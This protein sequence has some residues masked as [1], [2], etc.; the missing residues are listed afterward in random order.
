MLSALL[1]LQGCGFWL[2]W[3]AGQRGVAVSAIPILL[4][5]CASLVRD[6]ARG[7][8]VQW[9]AGSWTLERVGERQGVVI[10]PATT[11]LPWV[12]YLTWRNQGTGGRGQL[13][14]FSDSMDRDKLRRLRARLAL[15]R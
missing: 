5:V 1:A 4:L 6:P 8:I 3:Q 11:C 14:L 13:W 7:T 2:L 12:V 9:R 10:L 15:E